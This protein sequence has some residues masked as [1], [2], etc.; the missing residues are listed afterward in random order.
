[1]RHMSKNHG[2]PQQSGISQDPFSCLPPV[3][4]RRNLTDRHRHNQSSWWSEGEK[5]GGREITNSISQH[6]INISPHA[7]RLKATREKIPPPPLHKNLIMG[8]RFSASP[9]HPR[10]EGHN[11]V[12]NKEARRDG[13]RRTIWHGMNAREDERTQTAVRHEARTF[14]LLARASAASSSPCRAALAVRHTFKCWR[15][16]SGEW[17]WGATVSG[18]GCKE[19][20]KENRRRRNQQWGRRVVALWH[21]HSLPF[22][23]GQENASDI[24]RWP[25]YVRLMS[26]SHP[27]RRGHPWKIDEPVNVERARQ[28]QITVDGQTH[29]PIMIPV[30][31]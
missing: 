6:F 20:R 31:V 30:D 14:G 1:M 8:I 17:V 19:R 18:S 28:R 24:H 13:R 29:W 9:Q 16:T 10:R 5:G 3:T 4:R 23:V 25:Y 21:D 11:N 7:D 27:P 15:P 26:L 22:L 12:Y 2:L